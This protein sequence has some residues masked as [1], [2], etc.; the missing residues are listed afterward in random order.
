MSPTSSG[1]D[2]KAF[3]A[4]AGGSPQA[5]RARIAQ[6]EQ[7]LAGLREELRASRQREHALHERQQRIQLVL[8]G[9]DVGLWDWDVASDEVTFSP[10]WLLRLDCSGDEK[11]A[12]RELLERTVHPDDREILEQAVGQHFEGAAFCYEVEHRRRDAQGRWRWI[13]DRGRV[14]CRDQAGRPVRAVGMHL[15]VTHRKQMEEALWDSEG[16]FRNAFENAALGLA[17]GDA[18]EGG[19]IIESNEALERMLQARPG[20]LIGRKFTELL[21]AGDLASFQELWD[22]MV[23]GEASSFRSEMRCVRADG[24]TLRGRLTLSLIRDSRREPLYALAI[25]EDVTERFQAERRTQAEQQLLRKLLELQ[26]CERR[27]LAYEIHDGLV[28]DLVASKLL[29]DGAS[30]RLENEQAD[31]SRELATSLELLGKAIDEGRRLISD[32]R[33]MIIDEMGVVEAIHYLV[34]EQRDAGGLQIALEHDTQFDRLPQLLE[35][36]VYRIVQEALTN[37]KRHARTREVAVSLRQHGA[38]LEIVV[39]DEGVGFRPEEVSPDR[40]GVRGIQERARLFGGRAS[41]ESQPGRGTRVRVEL[42]LSLPME[43]TEL[44][45][46]G[47]V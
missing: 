12:W 28:Q 32:L 9:S 38:T 47:A 42:P 16:R 3:A 27:L 13:L 40:F 2:P 34:E 20:E 35:G 41:V 14:V 29:L 30:Y 44:G 23:R 46:N 36:T 18:Q 8:E 11:L 19:L 31:V 26:D 1:R 6:L 10:H 43:E 4:G 25:V 33:P 24:G 7:E 45:T 22:R 21:H 5:D 15:D 37:V 39:R 17:M